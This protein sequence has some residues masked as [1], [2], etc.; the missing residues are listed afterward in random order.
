MR[1]RCG[2]MKDDFICM[3]T[4]ANS[5]IGKATS[6]GL[7]KIGARVV[8]VCR[9]KA[10]GEE[11]VKDIIEQTGN[12]KIDLL[13]SDLADMNSVRNLAKKFKKKYKQLDVLILNAGGYNT[14]RQE[15]VDGFERTIA[16]SFISRFLLTN[17]LLKTLEV[18]SPA[19]II[20]VIGSHQAKE[21][22]FDDFMMKENYKASSALAHTQLANVLFIKRLAKQLS[23]NGVTINGVDPGFVRTNFVEK[24][25]DMPKWLKFMFKFFK[26]F[27]KPPTRAAEIV[28]YA[29]IAPDLAA[30][31]GGILSKANEQPDII[32]IQD[33][34]LTQQL[35]EYVE[36]LLNN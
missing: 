24:D 25:K 5:G 11:A 9:D 15:T 4:G 27:A 28:L 30:T 17:L 7:A 3:V 19:R 31:S 36:K 21:L 6:L 32:T 12:S 18:S 34:N 2:I 10:K 13:I 22:N 14:K 16:T 20:S 35:W 26:P 29:A 8:L 33:T 1:N 23:N